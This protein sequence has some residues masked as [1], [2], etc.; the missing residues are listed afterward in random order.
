MEN[1]N[2][3][4]KIQTIIDTKIVTNAI[5]DMI[6][7]KYKIV[8]KIVHEKT[9]HKE[10]RYYVFYNNYKYTKLNKFNKTNK[11]I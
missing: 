6:Y 7:V 9:T 1:Q 5:L 11:N 2:I 10:F 3:L 8:K 4:E